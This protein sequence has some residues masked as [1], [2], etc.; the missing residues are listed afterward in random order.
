VTE[1]QKPPHFPRSFQWVRYLFIN[2]AA[3]ITGNFDLS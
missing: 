2:S 1:A 3:P